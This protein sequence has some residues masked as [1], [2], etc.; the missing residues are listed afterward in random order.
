[1]LS[2]F[3]A[4][5]P[6]KT[7]NKQTYVKVKRISSNVYRFTVVKVL[8]LKETCAVL[9]AV[10]RTECIWSDLRHGKC[11]R[12]NVMIRRAITFSVDVFR[13]LKNY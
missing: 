5:V 2:C 3:C 12:K 8:T 9:S 4:F 1:M 13:H 10:V 7:K 11:T 6:E